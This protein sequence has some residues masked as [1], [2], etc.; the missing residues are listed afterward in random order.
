MSLSGNQVRIVRTDLPGP[1]SGF[2][3]VYEGTIDA[4]GRV[5]GI[6]TY[7]WPARGWKDR[8]QAWEAVIMR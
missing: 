1:N 7:T 2:S 4:D 6:E 5:T 3:A 8:Q